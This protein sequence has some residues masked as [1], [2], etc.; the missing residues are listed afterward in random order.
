MAAQAGGS[1]AQG[2][3]E[4]L[5]T[6]EDGSISVVARGITFPI[7]VQEIIKGC[8]EYLALN[9]EDDPETRTMVNKHADVAD[10][11]MVQMQVGPNIYRQLIDAIGLEQADVM[12][13]IHDELVKMPA[14]EFNQKMQGLIAGT[15]EGK[16]WFQQMAQRI[17]Q[18]IQADEQGEQ[19]GL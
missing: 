15:P 6:N 4:R 16:Q 10:D 1:E 13:Y 8:M 18:E 3:D 5:K 12:P 2:G 14:S 17:K 19:T 11:E 9:D 7:L